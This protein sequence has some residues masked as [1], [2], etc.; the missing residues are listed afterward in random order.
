MQKGVG[1]KPASDCHQISLSYHILTN[2]TIVVSLVCKCVN[3]QGGIF[4]NNLKERHNIT[5]SAFAWEILKKLKVIQRKSIS[6][7]IEESLMRELKEKGYN[8]TYFKI[9]SSVLECDDKENAEITKALDSLKEDDLE[10]ADEYELENKTIQK[11]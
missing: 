1:G 7:I 2:F 11:R 6:E 10:V 8:P 3:T 9:M 4:M 5:M